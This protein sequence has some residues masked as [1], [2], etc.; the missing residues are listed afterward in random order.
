MSRLKETLTLT[1]VCLNKIKIF[2]YYVHFPV[3][4]FLKNSST[5]PTN[6]Q[7]I[8]MTG[9]PRRRW[10]PVFVFSGFFFL[11]LQVQLVRVN[12]HHRH[13]TANKYSTAHPVGGVHPAGGIY[14]VG[15]V[16][17]SDTI[18]PGDTIY[19]TDAVHPVD[20]VHPIDAVPP[21]T[22]YTLL[23]QYIPLM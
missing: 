12:V 19:S 3:S 15:G 6:M 4:P 23:T 16:H 7:S 8:P 10:V 18:K 1:S 2:E 22:Q 13:S 11:V 9:G 14:P 21:F 20:T 17:P 5:L